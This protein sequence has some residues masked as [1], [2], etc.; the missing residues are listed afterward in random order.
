M[1]VRLEPA[2]GCA[3]RVPT[4]SRHLVDVDPPIHGAGF[5][6][7]GEI[8]HFI[9]DFV[10]TRTQFARQIEAQGLI[11]ALNTEICT[12]YQNTQS[13]FALP[14]GFLAFLALRTTAF[15]KLFQE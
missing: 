10:G 4:E 11:P 7:L 2:G 12:G 3:L 15:G 9:R 13:K 1:L 8:A 14:N 5:I 6:N